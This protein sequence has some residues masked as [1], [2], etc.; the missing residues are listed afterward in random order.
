M[1][2]KPPI[3][4]DKSREG[5][6]LGVLCLVCYTLCIWGAFSSWLVYCELIHKCWKL[7]DA[8]EQL[9]ETWHVKGAFNRYGRTTARNPKVC[10]DFVFI[11]RSSGATYRL[12]VAVKLLHYVAADRLVILT[13]DP[14]GGKLVHRRDTILACVGVEYAR[15]AINLSRKV[16]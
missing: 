7:L 1:G 12:T 3:Y 2:G 14:A 6:N 16:V 4:V 10:Y 15:I 11:C 5:S 13:T 9:E 8:C